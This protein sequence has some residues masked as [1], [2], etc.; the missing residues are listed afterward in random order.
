MRIIGSFDTV[1]PRF[2]KRVLEPL[3]VAYTP[4]ER[5]IHAALRKY[6]EL[7]QARCEDNAE[8]FA[9]EF[10]L[11]T[12]KKRPT[13]PS[14]TAADGRRRHGSTEPLEWLRLTVTPGANAPA[15][16]NA[17]GPFSW[18]RIAFVP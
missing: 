2:P 5:A 13:A 16:S 6:A 17:F 1:S 14:A 8:K 15:G 9:T 3:E 4:Q 12:L 11:K 18:E 10:V 7:R